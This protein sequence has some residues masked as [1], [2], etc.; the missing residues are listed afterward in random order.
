MDK[1]DKF[2]TLREDPF[3]AVASAAFGTERTFAL[4]RTSTF[5]TVYATSPLACVIHDSVTL[6]AS[7][8][9]FVAS[10]GSAAKSAQ[11]SRTPRPV[12]VPP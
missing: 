5:G 10:S 8:R 11:V 3:E 7:M 2:E 12:V 4:T 6:H 1:R 9:W